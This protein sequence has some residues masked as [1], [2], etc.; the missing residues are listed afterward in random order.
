MRQSKQSSCYPCLKDSV[1][2][3]HVSEFVKERL[4]LLIHHVD[5]N[6]NYDSIPEN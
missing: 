2:S 6:E 1:F 3:E 5:R 4:G